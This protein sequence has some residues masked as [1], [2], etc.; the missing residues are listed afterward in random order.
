MIARR[1]DWCGLPVLDED[2]YFVEAYYPVKREH[3]TY[4]VCWAC[5]VAH[6]RWTLRMADPERFF[7]QTF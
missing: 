7:P 1:C 5:C 2:M 4:N 3:R 6:W